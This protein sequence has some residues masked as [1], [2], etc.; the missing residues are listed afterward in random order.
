MR[1]RFAALASATLLLLALSLCDSIRLVGAAAEAPSRQTQVRAPWT[2]QNVELASLF[3]AVIDT[4]SKHFFDETSLKQHHWAERAQAMRSSVLAS[5]DAGDAV[6][7]INALLAEL[8]AS[9]TALYTP[10]DYEY[11][12]LLDILGG[13]QAR[14]VLD[15]R[16]WGS[17]PYYPGIGI[18]TR[19]IGEKSFIDGVLEG[20][21]ADKSGL[22]FGDEILSVDGRPYSRVEAFDGKIG[23]SAEVAIRRTATAEPER[24]SINVTPIRPVQA[25]ADAT[26]ASARIIERNDSRIGYVHVWALAE[27]A[28]FKEALRKFDPSSIVG[29]RLADQP[30][31]RETTF[32]VAKE[33]P[34]P[35]DFLIVDLRGRVGGNIAVSGELLKV[36]DGGSYWGDT[37]AFGRSFGPLGTQTV[38][39]RKSSYRGRS[40]L[41]I[42]AH[43]R[44]AGEYVAYGYKRCGFGPLLGTTTAGAVLSGSLYAMPGDMLLYLAVFGHE[45]D[46]HR[47]EGAGVTP[48]YHVEQ[49]LPYAQGADPVLEAAANLLSGLAK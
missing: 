19:Q 5:S 41:L 46:G 22:K 40:A 34:K 16:F 14:D 42:D 28:S 35:I 26:E 2:N 49:P 21:P 18:F 7:Q 6:R 13:L 48:D 25:F 20:S 29:K 9:H 27:A 36:L 39:L 3:D 1:L 15:R 31:T 44:S 12:I 45:V 23:T 10:N 11:Y 24:L 17:G 38:D 37:R 8:G 33:M 47:L 32:A 30:I 43:T 4:V